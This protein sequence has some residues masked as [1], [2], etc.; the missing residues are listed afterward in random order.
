[1]NTWREGQPKP[2]YCSLKVY[3]NPVQFNFLSQPF[4]VTSRRTT[5]PFTS[6]KIKSGKLDIFMPVLLFSETFFSVKTTFQ[7]KSISMPLFSLF[8][9]RICFQC[10]FFFFFNFMT[11]CCD[12]I[13]P[14]YLIRLNQICEQAVVTVI[15]WILIMQGWHHF[16]PLWRLS[17]L[18]S[19]LSVVIC[20]IFWYCHNMLLL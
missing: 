18:N 17:W 7:N 3:F 8:Q 11:Q 20:S 5:Y 6:G 2:A 4:C 19:R 10:H 15:I 14:C 12:S 13:R 1:M 16:Y 9:F